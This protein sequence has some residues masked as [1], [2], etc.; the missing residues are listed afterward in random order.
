MSGSILLH[1]TKG[2]NPKLTICQWCGGDAPE[3]ALIGRHD[4]I[5][6][7]NDCDMKLYGGKSLYKQKCPKC[8]Q[9]GRWTFDRKI[10]DYERLPGGPCDT[11]KKKIEAQNKRMA[12]SEAEVAAGG[13]FWK[14]EKCGSEGAI[15]RTHP[16]CAAVRK[17]MNKP[18]P[19][20]C[21]V[22][23]TPEE[24]PVC[25]GEMDKT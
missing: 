4:S 18:T 21:G 23:M 11:C 16:I 17:Q 7:C 6:K 9:T 15:K 3:L 10:G 14:C 19:E 25:N 8:G 5:Y 12:D 20:R 2:V 13:I 24:C 22:A 1:P